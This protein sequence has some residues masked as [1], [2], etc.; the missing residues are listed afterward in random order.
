MKEYH[1]TGE[2]NTD[3]RSRRGRNHATRYVEEECSV[4][5]EY[6]YH[7]GPLTAVMVP[8]ARHR[9]KELE[10]I[11]QETRGRYDVQVKSDLE[12]LLKLQHLKPRLALNELGC[13]R[14]HVSGHRRIEE[15]DSKRKLRRSR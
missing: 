15:L 13:S 6:W 8:Y 11:S 2:N 9:S 1:G 5:S 4:Q 14:L 12:R 3:T 7:D 10:S